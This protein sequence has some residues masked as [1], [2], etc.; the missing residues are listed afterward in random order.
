M[1]LMTIAGVIG[2][3]ITVF[4]WGF[5]AGGTFE[6]YRQGGVKD[7]QR[8]VHI[9]IREYDELLSLLSTPPLSRAGALPASVQ[10]PVNAVRVER[11]Q[12]SV[13]D[14]GA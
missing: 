3:A 4:T 14:G 1:S 5:I 10:H 7:L 11:P 13:L 8:D 9:A 6:T 2:L 12:L